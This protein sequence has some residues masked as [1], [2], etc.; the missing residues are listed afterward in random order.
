MLV[1]PTSLETYNDV[2]VC[3]N[4]INE[5]FQNAL[6]SEGNGY[7][8]FNFGE[9]SASIKSIFPLPVVVGFYNNSDDALTQLN[10]IIGIQNFQ[11]QEIF[12]RIENEATKTCLGGGT[13]NLKINPLPQLNGEEEEQLL[14]VNNPID[15]PQERS[16]ILNG[17]SDITTDTYQWYFN[18]LIIP[19]ATNST[20]AAT[21]EGIYKIEA[22]R[23]NHNNSTNTF[24]DTMC[25]GFNTFKVIESNFAVITDNDITII[26]DSLNNSITIE[27]NNLG[28]GAYEFAIKKLDEIMSSFQAEPYFESLSPG[29]YTLF[30]RDK[31]N[32]GVTLIDI[33]IIGFPKF[34]TPNNDGYNDTWGVLG[35]NENFYASS[36][37]YIF[38]RYGKLITQINPKS[39]GWNGMFNGENLPA[40]DYWFSVELIDKNGNVRVRKGHFSLIRR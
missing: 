16:V 19:L 33:S 28:I 9:I 22:S 26:D 30:I 21:N 34:F 10:E 8:T 27:T 39:E 24:D 13:F 40:T 5:T 15:T 6:K 35:V 1:L 18:N 32:C 29:I 23:I 14:C 38:N 7:G 17:E 3:E 31:N 25:I 11:P 2:Y 12:L 4:D 36:N 20:F 37:I